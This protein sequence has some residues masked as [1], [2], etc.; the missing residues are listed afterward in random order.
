MTVGRKAPVQGPIGVPQPG[1]TAGTRS[2][3]HAPRGAWQR[4]LDGERHHRGHSRVPTSEVEMLDESQWQRVEDADATRRCSPADCAA[5]RSTSGITFGF[6]PWL[7]TCGAAWQASTSSFTPP[8]CTSPMSATTAGGT[9]WT[10]TCRGL[11]TGSKKRRR[12]DRQL[13]FTSTTSTFGR[14]LNPPPGEPAAW[15]TEDVAPVPSNIYGATKAAAEDLCVLVARDRG[16]PCVI[17][18]TSRLFPEADDR[19]EVRAATR[20]QPSAAHQAGGS[21]RG[22]SDSASS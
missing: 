15:I 9:S 22:S 8:R 10:P 6:G 12:R 5:G 16:L 21:W 14:A 7:R 20:R 17:L 2:P 18:R 4:L 13:V 19:D 1:R 11:S 3:A